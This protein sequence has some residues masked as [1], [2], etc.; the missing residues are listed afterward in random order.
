MSQEE[1]VLLESLQNQSCNSPMFFDAL[2]EDEDVVEVHANHAFHD[3]VLEN[4][5]H[6]RLEGRGRISE[7]KKH[8]QG[9]VEAVIST[10]RRLPLVTLL[11][12]NI[13]VPSV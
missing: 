10:K 9:F 5:V 8:H 6:H 12:S 13:L 1:L 2:C 4:V 7:S 3:E 11:H